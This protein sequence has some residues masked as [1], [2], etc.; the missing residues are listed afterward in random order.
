MI[1]FPNCKI[2]LGLNITRKRSDGFHD[3]ETVFYPIPVYDVLEIIAA[4]DSLSAHTNVSFTSGGITIEGDKEN[5]LCIKAYWLLKKDFPGLPAIQMYLH[6]T[7]PVGAGLGGGSADAAF[8]LRL[9]NENFQLN[10]STDQLINYSLQLGSDI[11][12]F[13][14]NKPCFASGRGELLEQVNI[15]LAGYKFALV[16]PG[17]TINTAYAF[18]KVTP[19]LPGQSIK[20]IIQD[21]V[22]TWKEKLKNDFEDSVFAQHPAIKKIKDD[23]YQAGATYASMS[24]SGSSV[25]GIFEKEKDLHLSFPRHYFVRELIS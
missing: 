2:N 5:N 8:T 20:E 9:L 12:F 21:P 3:L 19:A 14:I 11:P 4:T 23:L 7:I 15:D 25:Y 16:N 1:V 18:S 6:K 22:A 24:G 13:I 10:L 17:I